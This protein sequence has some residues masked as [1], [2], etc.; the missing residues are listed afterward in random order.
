MRR[1]VLILVAAALLAMLSG[2]AVLAYAGTSDR[3]ALQGR[4]G[5]WVLLATGTIPA[6]TTIAQIR[7][8]R[9]VRQVLM[10]VAT[11]PS[12]AV[13][14]L[15]PSMDDLVLNAPL[16]P[17]QM[18]LRGQLDSSVTPH[19]TPTFVVPKGRIAVS[20]LLN[21]APQVAGN[22]Q[23]G[24]SVAVFSLVK[25][26]DSHYPDNLHKFTVVLI[27]KATVIT[28]GEAPAAAATPTSTASASPSP[29][30]NPTA[31]ATDDTLQRY[32]VTLAVDQADAEVLITGAGDNS[33]YLGKLG[34]NATM[35][36]ADL[37]ALGLSASSAA[38]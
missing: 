5:T 35:S 37:G 6:H 12:G 14:K 26:K 3:R 22:V 13:S 10:P 21:I 19:A 17:D 23:P 38:S 24:D 18:L 15:E 9:L 36:P 11:V 25:Q 28:V 1:R 8:R 27:P 34:A 20:V 4:Q 29:S 32:V 30:P 16:Q 2:L 33:L 7:S 31:T